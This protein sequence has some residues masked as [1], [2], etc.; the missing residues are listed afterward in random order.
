MQESSI[1]SKFEF[2][3]YRID[4]AD[5]KMQP[6]VSLLATP[7]ISGILNWNIAL[8]IRKPFFFEKPNLYVTGL[9]CKLDL[10]QKGSSE[11]GDAGEKASIATLTIGIVGSFRPG[12][13]R[14][15][16][17]VEDQLVKVQTPALLFSYLRAAIGS[18]LANAGFGVFIVPLINVHELATAQLDTLEITIVT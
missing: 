9:D 8:Q 1:K 3:S 4:K 12:A 10:F 2:V 6:N 17:D 18:F 7:A 16:K 13:Q 5:F 11:D 14:F 15:E